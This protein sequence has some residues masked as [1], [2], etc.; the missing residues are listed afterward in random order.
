MTKYSTAVV[1]EPVVKVPLELNVVI[2]SAIAEL[3]TPTIPPLRS[4][5]IR[6]RSKLY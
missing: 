5:M 6:P 4:A 1:E 2:T 3:S